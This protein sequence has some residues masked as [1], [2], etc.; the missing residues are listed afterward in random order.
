MKAAEKHAISEG[1]K[2]NGAEDSDKVVRAV[3]SERHAHELR[4]LDRQ[5]AA[6]KK[7]MV[8]DALVKLNDRYDKRRDEL[9]RKHDAQLEQLQVLGY[10]VGLC[11]NS[12]KG[13]SQ[14]ARQLYP[15]WK[16]KVF[17]SMDS[18][19]LGPI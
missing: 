14:A 6:E 18:I 12:I 15:A 13:Y 4:D 17:F 2:Q 1:V 16:V 7:I 10:S 5:Y 11:A 19:S 9:Q 3:L 8:D